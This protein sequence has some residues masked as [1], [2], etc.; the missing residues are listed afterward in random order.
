MIK[1]YLPQRVGEVLNKCSKHSK[2]I[3]EIEC[4]NDE[5]IKYLKSEPE[6][7]IAGRVK[8][9]PRNKIGTELKILTPNKLLTRLPVLLA[10][11]KAVDNSEKLK[12]D[13][14]NKITKKLYNNLF[15]TL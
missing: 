2:S 5:T 3:G 7:T 14:H 10:Q 1:K 13:K 4:Y 12:N 6:Q 9:N 8:L 11:I 15:K